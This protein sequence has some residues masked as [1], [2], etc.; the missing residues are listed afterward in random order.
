LV[1][2]KS[3]ELASI[4]HFES[5]EGSG[6]YQRR[7]ENTPAQLG[8]GRILA[9]AYHDLVKRSKVVPE[10]AR[11]ALLGQYVALAA[12][13]STVFAE[14]SALEDVSARWTDMRKALVR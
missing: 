4:R 5:Q 6:S 9:A 14:D 10:S 2:L 3:D 12:E 1:Q 13:Y 7:F 8:F 11:T